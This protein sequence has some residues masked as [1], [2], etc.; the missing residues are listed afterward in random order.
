MQGYLKRAQLQARV[1]E[2][3]K[4][5]PAVAILGARQVGKST[6]A[7]KILEQFKTSVFLDLQLPRELNKLSDP[8]AFF[9]LHKKSLICL[10]EIQ[11]KPDL[12][13]VL[14]G[15]IDQRKKN[16]QFLILGSAS[17]DLIRQSSESLAGRIAFLNITPFNA[18]ETGQKKFHQHWLRGGYPL[19]FLSRNDKVSLEWRYNYIRTFLERDIPQL[20]FNIPAQSLERLW[21]ILSHS[22]G[23]ILNSSKF[24]ETLGKSAHTIKNY[25]D[26]LEQTFTLRTLKPYIRNVKKR[27]I[28]SPKVYIRDT[29][30][31]HAYLDIE[32]TND[33]F[34]H[35]I[36]GV[37]FESYVIE[38]ICSRLNHWN[39]YF[40][41][42]SSGA[43]LDLVLEKTRQTIAIEIKASTSP[44][45]SKGFWNAVEDIKASKKYIIA[46]VSE[47]YPIQKGLIVTNVFSFLKKFK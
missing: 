46:P 39:Q 34:G 43:E 45:P 40:Y 29:G 35:P 30:L 13:P 9:E 24:G 4:D 11:Y 22:Q 26:I 16:G 44:K 33:L 3:L 6:L 18:Q 31:L 7:K 8:E 17:R 37:S 5:Y 47:T 20:G 38:N 36:Y 14:R 23:Q 25:I 32:T 27:L 28:K 12:F 10:D 19:S 21:K 42:T 1:K 2:L 15:V 41:R